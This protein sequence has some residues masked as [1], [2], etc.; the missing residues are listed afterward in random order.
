MDDFIVLCESYGDDRFDFRAFGDR[1]QLKLEM[2]YAHSA[3]TT[4]GRPRPRPPSHGPSLRC[5][6]Q[7]CDVLLD[8]P[9]ERW[10]EFFDA[11]HAARH[12]K[13]GQLAF[14][15]Y[16][17]RSVEDCTSGPAGKPNSQEMFGNCGG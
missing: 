14:L 15:R 12:G 1:R 2:Q 9:I 16:A 7:R 8:W 17:H 11:R 5:G 4:S 3:D 10:T 13:N 6:R